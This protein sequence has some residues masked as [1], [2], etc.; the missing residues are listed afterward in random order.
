MREMVI[1]AKF[2]QELNITY[3]ARIC[4]KMW[5]EQSKRFN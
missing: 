3:E 5:L 1:Q 2:G 4:Y